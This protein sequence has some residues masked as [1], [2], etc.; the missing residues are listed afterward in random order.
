MTSMSAVEPWAFI[1]TQDFKKRKEFDVQVT[2][3]RDF[4][5]LYKVEFYL[6]HVLQF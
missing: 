4:N 6:Q 1:C 3:H 5:F 2:V